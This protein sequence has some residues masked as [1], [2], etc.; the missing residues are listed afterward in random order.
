[1]DDLPDSKISQLWY[2]ALVELGV[3]LDVVTKI[4][5]R[6]YVSNKTRQEMESPKH[7]KSVRNI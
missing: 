3:E 5:L 6:Q 1:M 2:K 7:P 4:E